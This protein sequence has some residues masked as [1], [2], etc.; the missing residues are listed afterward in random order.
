MGVF[1]ALSSF[2]EKLHF[3]V[4]ESHIVEQDEEMAKVSA[5]GGEVDVVHDAVGLLKQ[6]QRASI[7]IL[8]NKSDR[9]LVEFGNNYRYLIFLYF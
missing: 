4:A 8:P 3:L 9:A 1:D 2:L 7:L 6:V 5:T